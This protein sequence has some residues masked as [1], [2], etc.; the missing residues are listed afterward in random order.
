[1]PVLFGG[2]DML[3]LVKIRLTDLT[4]SGGAITVPDNPKDDIP[5]ES[6]QELNFRLDIQSHLQL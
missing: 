1:M 5:V 4:K 2:H 6:L 3:P